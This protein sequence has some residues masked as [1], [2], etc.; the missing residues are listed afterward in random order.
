MTS[1][2]IL[3]KQTPGFP[4]SPTDHLREF[5]NPFIGILSKPKLKIFP[6]FVKQIFSFSQGNKKKKKKRR[7]KDLREIPELFS[8]L[9]IIGGKKRRGTESINFESSARSRLM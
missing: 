8:N 7:K 5:V 2:C 6:F 1:Q 9:L 4:D 3:K